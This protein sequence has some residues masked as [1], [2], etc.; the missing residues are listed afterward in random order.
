MAFPWIAVAL[1]GSSLIEGLLASNKNTQ[2]K[3]LRDVLAQRGIDLA[4]SPG[5]SE[6]AK[7]AIFG[8]NFG[9]IRGQQRA[10]QK[11][12]NEGLARAGMAGTSAAVTAGQEN[13]WSNE[14]LVSQ[15]LRDLLLANEQKVS[16]DIQTASGIL[17]QGAAT[18]GAFQKQAPPLTEALTS[19][20]MMSALNKEPSWMIPNQENI[21]RGTA[22]NAGDYSWLLD[23][24]KGAG[25]DRTD[26]LAS[27]FQ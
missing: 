17:G 20:L 6:A 8:T 12:T 15:S 22:A 3:K 1:L 10:V 13:A 4:S 5:Y 23:L 2:L 24:G 27:L 11:Q 25:A 7:K 21:Y 16:S 26:A 18:A 14:A 9:K 19:A